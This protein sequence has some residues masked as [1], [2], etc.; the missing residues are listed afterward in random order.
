MIF[1]VG[2]PFLLCAIQTAIYHPTTLLD[3]KTWRN[4]DSNQNLKGVQ[5]SMFCTYLFVPSIQINN[6]LEGRRTAEERKTAGK[7]GD[8]V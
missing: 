6:K 8:P 5:I 7:D 4:F 1:S 3:F 2:A